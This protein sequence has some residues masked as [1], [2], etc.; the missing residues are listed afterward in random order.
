[1][2]A[3]ED[4]ALGAAVGISS[5]EAA[6]A[7]V[8]AGVAAASEARPEGAKVGAGGG[9]AAPPGDLPTDAEG[10]RLLVEQLTQAVLR[11]TEL[12]GRLGAVAKGFRRDGK[13]LLGDLQQ[14]QRDMHAA[15]SQDIRRQAEALRGL[16][17]ENARLKD[18][19]RGL[20]DWLLAQGLQPPRTVEHAPGCWVAPAAPPPAPGPAR[21]EH[22]AAAGGPGA[23]EPAPAVP[24]QLQ[25]GGP[26]GG[27]PITITLRRQDGVALGLRITSEWD[28]KGLR[29]EGIEPGGA[30]AAWNRL[31][32][33][34]RA[35]CVGDVLIGVNGAVLDALGMLQECQR[36]MLLKLVI[37]RGR[38]G[39][40]PTGNKQKASGELDAGAPEFT[41]M[42]APP[43]RALGEMQLN[44]QAELGVASAKPRRVLGEMQCNSQ[45]FSG[46]SSP[47]NSKAKPPLPRLEENTL[48]ERENEENTPA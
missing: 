47:S 32:D 30:A 19:V 16:R 40:L 36:S 48:A 17:E 15:A 44:A 45:Q 6:A 29:I 34:P 8:A 31:C 24:A 39:P 18:A 46:C 11:K 10:R 33:P 27:R 14:W 42:M 3:E 23:P 9:L 13:K 37:A 1:M 12:D 35:I 25:G 21:Q 4:S 28:G 7:A 22:A 2:I 38:D 41:P 20:V 26:D 43:R 5:S